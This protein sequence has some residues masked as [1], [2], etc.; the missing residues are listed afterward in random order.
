MPEPR[1]LHID[2]LLTN[3]SVAYSNEEFIWPFIMP[4]V[5]VNKRSD[6]FFKRNKD[7]AFRI[8]DDA[9]GPKA[10]PNEVD[11][12]NTVDNYSVKDHAL[13]DWVPLETIDNADTPIQPEIE[14]NDLLNEQLDLAQENRVATIAFTAANYP[15]GNKVTLSG[16]SQWGQSAD[17]PIGNIMTA[18]E[19]CFKRANTLVFGAEA[20][21]KFRSLPEV[22]DAVKG[23]TRYQGSPGGLATMTEV[24]S[25]CEVDK[26]LVGRARKITSKPGQTDVYARVWGKHCAALYVNPTPGLKS[27]S[28]GYTFAETQKMT[29]KY[30]DPKRGVK[31]ATFIKTAWNS[32]EKVVAN[33]V[34]YMIENAIP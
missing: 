29:Q 23:S 7:V 1:D 2:T 27:I 22:L 11:W 17:D 15:A 8:S 25:L 13:A 3:L 19:T 20:W 33:D 21:I 9:I 4:P 34:G 12:G 14:A 30:F 5:K 26:V 10:L 6:K 32:D 18:I 31:G 24:A 28:F 16:T